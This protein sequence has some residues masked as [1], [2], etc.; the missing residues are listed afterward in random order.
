[1]LRHLI[2]MG[3]SGP[4]PGTGGRPPKALKDKLA[5]GYSRPL[6]VLDIPNNLNGVATPEPEKYILAK[7]KNGK[8]LYAE[9]IFKDTWDWLVKCKCEHLVVLPTINQ[10]AMSMARWIQCEEAI[11][12]FGF[13]AK[14]PTTNQPVQ[15]PFVSMSQSYMKQTHHLWQMI[16]QVVKENSTVDFDGN[17][18]QEATMELLLRA[19]TIHNN[20]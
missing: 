20:H 5:N 18:P 13:L 6:K 4:M 7:Q 17:T 16:Y 3:K 15:S 1:M 8:P 9:Q 14:H 19:R 10:Y 2:A 12:E 11:S